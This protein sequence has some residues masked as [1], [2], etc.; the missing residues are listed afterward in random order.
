MKTLVLVASL[1]VTLFVANA[2][3]AY[4][5]PSQPQAAKGVEGPDT[6]GNG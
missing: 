1:V 2:A 4:E 6:G 3:F 5:W